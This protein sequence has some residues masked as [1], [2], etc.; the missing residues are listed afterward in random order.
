MKT[1]RRI[2]VLLVPALMGIA[3][4]MTPAPARALGGQDVIRY[5]YSDAAMTQVI[6]WTEVQCQG[7]VLRHG[8]YE[9]GPGY[10][11]YVKQHGDVYYH[12]DEESCP[13][14][15][16]LNYGCVHVHAS[17]Y[18]TQD[19]WGNIDCIKILTEDPVSCPASMF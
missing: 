5:F 17:A 16:S 1:T 12:F 4:L 3:L 8:I 10:D 13:D 11:D 2:L 18:C 14:A 15:F 9:G 7:P 6:G 19:I